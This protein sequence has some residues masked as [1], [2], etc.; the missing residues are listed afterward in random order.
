[1][2]RGAP[3]YSNVTSGSPLHRLDDMAELA[4]R[5]G[6]PV[7]FNRSGDVVWFT[8]FEGGLQGVVCTS[9]HE[10]GVGLISSSRALDGC[11]S[12]K[13]DPRDADDS[14]VRWSRV[15]GL[16]EPGRIAIEASVS[17]DYTPDG[18]KLVLWYREGGREVVGRV[19]YDPQTSSW[20]IVDKDLGDV[21]VLEDY[22]LEKGSNAWHQIK[23]VIDTE[24]KTYRRLI[25]GRHSV[26]LTSYN[27]LDDPTSH[28][29][30]VYFRVECLGSPD[31][32]AAIYVDSVIITQNE[33]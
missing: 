19:L 2:P 5:L 28:V 32:H 8:S 3:D 27:L 22:G 7:S 31:N 25:S 12:L 17:L 16:L 20:A 14:Y 29:G 4:A 21:T 15:L 18:I 13:L 30:Q 10:D 23:L 33:P 1:M 11:F 9:D 24:E 6:S 26:D